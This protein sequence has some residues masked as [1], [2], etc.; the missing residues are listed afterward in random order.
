MLK[1]LVRTLGLALLALP[2]VP[3]AQSND[4]LVERYTAFAGSESNSKALV[5]GLRSGSDIQLSAGGS[6]TTID[7]PTKK[8]GGG[9]VNIALALAE[10]SLKQQGITHPTPEQ[11]KAA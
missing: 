7:P 2:L 6:T 5:T 1:T 9:N 10:A 3:S 8:M 11:I 4:K